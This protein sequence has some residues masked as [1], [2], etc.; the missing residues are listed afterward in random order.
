MRNGRSDSGADRTI[1]EPAEPLNQLCGEPHLGESDLKRHAGWEGCRRCVEVDE[2]RPPPREQELGRE[3]DALRVQRRDQ[4]VELRQPRPLRQVRGD[5]ERGLASERVLDEPGEVATSADVDEDPDAVGMHR[6]HGPA[7]LDGS[8]PLGDRQATDL[9][10]IGR[11]EARGA[12]RVERDGWTRDVQAL[13]EVT[14]R[15]D[16][17]GERG[18][19]IG[20]GKGQVLDH[21]PPIAEPRNDRLDVARR[22]GHDD[23]M[24]AVVDR[25]RDA[26]RAFPDLGLDPLAPRR[27]AHEPRR[28]DGAAR[29][30]SS[31]DRGEV[32]ESFLEPAIDPHGAGR[33]QREE[34]A[35]RM[36]GRGRGLQ[37]KTAQQL[38][39]GPLRREHDVDRRARLPEW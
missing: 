23:L 19:V 39:Q 35:A 24:W 33:G 21:H 22:A 10:R 34:F 32:I 17:R 1:T 37:S 31:E 12:A 5:G 30:E 4:M 18:C 2:P 25:D 3:R 9:R 15:S 6:L 13:E 7:E 38:I 11:H 27:D 36:A 16:Q 20:A 8:G 29:V 28:R 14:Q 26:A